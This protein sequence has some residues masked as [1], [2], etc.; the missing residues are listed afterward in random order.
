M[1]KRL[2]ALY[3]RTVLAHPLATLVLVLVVALVMA[4]GLPNFK[5]DASADALTLEYD[6][7]LD[8]FREISQRYGSSDILVV[9]YRP[10]EG[11]LF[12][13]ES[14]ATL[15]SL[16]RE[17]GNIPGVSNV[18]SLVNVPLLFSPKIEIADLKGEPRTLLT[19]GVDRAAA[20]REF[21]TSPIYRDLILGPDGQTTGIVANLEGDPRYLEMVRRRA[22]EGQGRGALGGRVTRA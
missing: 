21:Q 6:D 3:E 1:S 9:T 7:D 14:L 8:Y 5:I 4:A 22:L 20:K 15:D 18:Q 2:L 13:D 10:K 16:T 11:D 19:P 12:S 17:L